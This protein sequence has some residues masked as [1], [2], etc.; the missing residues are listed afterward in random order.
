MPLTAQQRDQLEQRLR[1]ERERALRALQRFAAE[2]QDLQDRT[3]ELGLYR[4]HLADI[5]TEAMEKETEF[6]LASQEG[7][8]LLEIDDALRRLYKE[9][10][11]FGICEECGAE[12]P[13][14]RL[15][16]LPYTRLC[17]AC[18]ERRERLPAPEAGAA[19]SGLGGLE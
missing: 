12:I 17:R 13:F 15:D 10:E 6:L 8:L 5:G 9:P 3:G 11:R 18:Q 2:S 16:V 4:L 14:E 1:R 7:R 19:E